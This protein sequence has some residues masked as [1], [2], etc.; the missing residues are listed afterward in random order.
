MYEA[1]Y[2]KEKETSKESWRKFPRENLWGRPFEKRQKINREF[3]R[4]QM[5]DHS[6]I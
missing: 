1:A 4:R 5:T 6:N 3:P 2:G